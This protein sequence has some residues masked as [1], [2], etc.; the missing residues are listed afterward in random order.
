M[1]NDLAGLKNRFWPKVQTRGAD[2]CWEWLANRNNKGYGLIREGGSRPKQLAHRIS[3]TLRHGP[4][5]D[6]L[7]VLHHCDN[8]GCVNPHHLFLG[9]SRDNSD[10]MHAKKR[11]R[12]VRG[13]GGH[14]PHVVGSAH[15]HAK[16][17][18]DDVI[19]IRTRL[20]N[21][22][23]VRSLAR[24]LGLD[25]STVRSIRDGKSWTHLDPTPI[26]Q[27]L[28]PCRGSEHANSKLTESQVREIKFLIANGTKQN[29]LATR[30]GVSVSTIS[31]IKRGL[32]WAWLT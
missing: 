26:R 19:S 31:E 4:I 13:Q 3:W 1:D 8:P 20:Q 32:I 12:Y 18:D 27:N 14:P 17:T 2:D 5:P 29:S 7:L 23:R 21:G 22:E 10:D 28:A 11:W 30:F 6:G 24:K 15:P 16:L 25:A 9:T